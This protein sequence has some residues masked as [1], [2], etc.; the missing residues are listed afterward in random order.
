M[1]ISVIIPT[2]NR[3]RSIA[4]TLNSLRESDQMDVEIIV[5]D[6][7]SEDQTVK[8]VE[9]LKIPNLI[10]VKLARK[11]NGNFARNEAI[12]ASSGDLV[13]F[14]DSDDEV[15]RSRLSGVIQYFQSRGDVDVLVDS[16]ITELNGIQRGF[17]F[18]EFELPNHAIREALIYHALPL[19]FSAITV[20]RTVIEQMGLLD[21]EITRHQDRDFLLS[22]LSAN[23]RIVLRNSADVI[24]HQSSDSFSRSGAGY[25]RALNALAA[26]HGLFK[27]G[28][29]QSLKEYLVLRSFLH[30]VSKL[31]LSECIENVVAYSKATA[32][33]PVRWHR[34]LAYFDGKRLRRELERRLIVS[35]SP[36]N[37]A[38]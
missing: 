36:K 3:E 13:V 22:A 29:H 26:K 32:L 7:A 5:V 20:R 17:Q 6:D 2:Y 4:R 30:S 34:L 25:I 16:F 11:T 38:V 35:H 10:L 19:T 18:K 12:R 1:K 15:L 23:L 37:P 24:K 27:S 28:E 14:L 31:D 33:K 21:E 8:T 9:A